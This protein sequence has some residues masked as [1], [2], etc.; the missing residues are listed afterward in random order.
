MIWSLM[1]LSLINR[2]IALLVIGKLI[3]IKSK[4]KAKRWKPSTTKT[5]KKTKLPPK[6]MKKMSKLLSNLNKPKIQS[7]NLTLKPQLKP[8]MMTKTIYLLEK[9]FSELNRWRKASQKAPKRTIKKKTLKS[10]ANLLII[11]STR[12]WWNHWIDQPSEINL[13]KNQNKNI[14]RKKQTK[15]LQ[16]FSTAISKVMTKRKKTPFWTDG[17]VSLKMWL[18]IKKSRKKTWVKFWQ[19][20]SK[21]WWRKM[22]LRMWL[23]KFQML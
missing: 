22:S 9:N 19:S 21:N 11:K 2:L 7:H 6:K 12:N 5:K 14:W 13:L 10:L 17:W 3:L 8:I 4:T 18:E 20:L 15:K 16:D 23:S 1:P